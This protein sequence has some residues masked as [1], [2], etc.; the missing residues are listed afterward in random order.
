M[1]ICF[2]HVAKFDSKMSLGV[3]EKSKSQRQVL[4]MSS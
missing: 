3:P 1:P 4:G 2:G